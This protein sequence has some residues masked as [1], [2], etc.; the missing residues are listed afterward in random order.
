MV[1]DGEQI[2]YVSVDG[3]SIMPDS[4]PRELG[5]DS[6]CVGACIGVDIES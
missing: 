6:A 2:G 3:R 1:I 5:V 4:N